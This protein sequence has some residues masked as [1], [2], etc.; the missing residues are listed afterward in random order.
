MLAFKLALVIILSGPLI[1]KFMA[2]T[3]VASEKVGEG[4]RGP[5]EA[6]RLVGEMAIERS[7]RGRGMA[8]LSLGVLRSSR[9]RDLQRAVESVR[10]AAVSVKTRYDLRLVV[11]LL[12]S[13][14]TK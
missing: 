1:P 2:D 3:F 5:G 13:F 9:A 8:D 10:A 6:G 11:A 12:A 14:N 7:E 4:G